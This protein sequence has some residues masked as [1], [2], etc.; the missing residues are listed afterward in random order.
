MGAMGSVKQTAIKKEGAKILKEHRA[1]LT[2]DF[3][4]NQ[5]FVKTLLNVNKIMSNRLAGYITRKMNMPEGPRKKY[6]PKK[7]LKA[8]RRPGPNRRD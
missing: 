8:G 7:P 3:D 6:V 2:K 1:E 4:K 5:E